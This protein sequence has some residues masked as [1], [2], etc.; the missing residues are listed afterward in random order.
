MGIRTDWMAIRE[1]IPVPSVARTDRGDWEF[2]YAQNIRIG[3]R[4]GR[5]QR[6]ILLDEMVIETREIVVHTF[7][8]GD[9][10][11]PDLYAA[12]PLWDWQQSDQGQWVMSNALETPIWSRMTDPIS[13]GYRYIITATFGTKALT[14]FYLRFG[15]PKPT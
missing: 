10:E 2:E 5:I 4:N 3:P 8:M 12:E 7:T 14:E 13:F 1:R 15:K 9:V 6:Y 11:D